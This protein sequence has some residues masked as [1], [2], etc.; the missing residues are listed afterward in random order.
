MEISPL[1]T[2]PPDLVKYYQEAMRMVGEAVSHVRYGRGRVT[3]FAP[4]RIEITFDD[5]TARTFAYPQS[6]GR[7]IRFEDEAADRRAGQDRERA[8]VLD[9]EQTMARIL[10]ERQRAEE[11]AQQ[12][13]EA[14]REKR[15]A[16]A[17]RNMARAAMAREKK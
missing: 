17:R 15:I 9:G 4:P 6:V 13:L 2:A 3:A 12:R 14:L 10:A 16:S 8:E 5:G 7:F 1:D 11:T